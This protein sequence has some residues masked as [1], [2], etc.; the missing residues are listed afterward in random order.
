MLRKM[1]FAVVLI[2][3]LIIIFIIILSF[4]LAYND[5]QCIDINKEDISNEI[6]FSA[7]TYLTIGYGDL[8]P[9]NTIGKV[10]VG[11]EGIVGIVLNTIMTG[12]LFIIYIRNMNNLILP[13]KIYIKLKDDKK[14][15]CTKIGNKSGE[16]IDLKVILE[17]FE[18]DDDRRIRRFELVKE[19]QYIEKLVYIHFD[20]K[21]ECELRKLLK[22]IIINNKII[23][24]RVTVRGYDFLTGN[25]VYATKNYKT[26]DIKFIKEFDMIYK[27]KNGKR[28]RVKW[29][30][31]DEVSEVSQQEKE[32]FLKEHE[33]IRITHF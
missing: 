27:W 25:L 12:F 6:Y 10:L 9:T 3:Y 33:G 28:S 29:R 1:S 17:I 21:Q 19:K 20:L 16:I 5:Y 7:I 23:D 8:C 15:L 4:A 30:N 32:K 22:D 2:S 31:F 18:F 13:K 26:K 14:Y 24:L 11:I